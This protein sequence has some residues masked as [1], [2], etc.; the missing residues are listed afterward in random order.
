[1][2]QAYNSGNWEKSRFYANKLL[3]KPDESDLAKSV[4]IRSYWNQGNLEKVGEM[5]A[6]WKNDSLDFIREKY[7]N[8][9]K[10][11]SCLLYTSPSPRDAT[12]SRMPSSA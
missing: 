2:R 11:Y 1:M 10:I 5:L 6:I 9:T 3:S 8:T 4:I 12:L 7:E